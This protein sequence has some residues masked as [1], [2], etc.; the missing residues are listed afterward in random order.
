MTWAA[1]LAGLALAVGI[2][3]VWRH[4]LPDASTFRID[5]AGTVFVA[6]MGSMSGTRR[7]MPRMRRTRG[8]E[9]QELPES[10]K[11]QKPQKPQELR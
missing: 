8:R 4:R 9:P 10:Q 11:P 3:W 1:C 2:Y 7:R 6:V 5:I